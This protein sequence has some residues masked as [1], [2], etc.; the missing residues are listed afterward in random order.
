MTK[1]RALAAYILAAYIRSTVEN[2]N[3][4]QPHNLDTHCADG[5]VEVNNNN[6]VGG[7]VKMNGEY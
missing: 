4:K 3:D 1:S 7:Y 2:A 5:D 6:E